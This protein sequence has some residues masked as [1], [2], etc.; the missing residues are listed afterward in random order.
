MIASE[1]DTAR[2]GRVGVGDVKDPGS[3]PGIGFPVQ[4]QV[5]GDRGGVEAL[6]HPVTALSAAP[7]YSS[8][9]RQQYQATT[10]R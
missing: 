1:P 3:N 2:L 7:P 6:A 4:N 9:A 8:A 10:D 5:R